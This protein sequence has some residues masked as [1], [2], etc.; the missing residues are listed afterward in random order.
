MHPQRNT[1]SLTKELNWDDFCRKFNL[2]FISAHSIQSGNMKRSY[3][4]VTEQGEFVA[5]Q[6]KYGDFLT[7]KFDLIR[8]VSDALNDANDGIGYPKYV[9]TTNGKWFVSGYNLQ[10]YID[11]KAPIVNDKCVQ[12]CAQ[13]LKCFHESC[14]LI[15]ERIEENMLPMRNLSMAEP[16]YKSALQYG[17]G[18]IHGEFRLRN[19]LFR[20]SSSIAI[21]DLDSICLAPR[22]IDIGYLMLDFIEMDVSNFDH[23]VQVIHGAYSK[24]LPIQAGYSAV[25]LLLSDYIDKC[26]SG[27][28]LNNRVLSIKQYKELLKK[29]SSRCI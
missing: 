25:A 9:S 3:L 12:I 6:Y 1:D 14:N 2:S 7:E 22:Y 29:L 21:I 16:T 11:N 24:N 13:T 17:T 15:E 20:D 10:R 28:I 23:Y 26:S 8:T 5:Q 4:I 19:I 18:I 27:Y